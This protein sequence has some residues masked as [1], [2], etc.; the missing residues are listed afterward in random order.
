M[1]T[2]PHLWE[3]LLST[4][5][6]AQLTELATLLG[7]ECPEQG[8]AYLLGLLSALDMDARELPDNAT[9]D[10]LAASVNPQRLGNHPEKLD[11]QTLRQIY[12]E[13]LT[14]MQQDERAQLAQRWRQYAQ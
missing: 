4:P 2:L 5:R 12:V 1:L 3:R 10:A 13:A 9:L 6:R 7:L 11:Q 8:R 14:P